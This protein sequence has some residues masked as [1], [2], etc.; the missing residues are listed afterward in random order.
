MGGNPGPRPVEHPPVLGALSTDPGSHR[1]NN[2]P[3]ASKGRTR[4]GVEAAGRLQGS[5][6]AGLG[7]SQG[8]TEGN[9]LPHRQEVNPQSWQERRRVGCHLVCQGWGSVISEVSP[10]WCLHRSCSIV[11]GDYIA[12]GGLGDDKDEET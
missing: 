8:L 7:C 9:G 3:V 11:W 5:V 2:V 10:V 6:Q 4:R 12:H 1:G